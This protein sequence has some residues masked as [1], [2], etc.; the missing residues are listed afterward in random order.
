[1]VSRKSKKSK[2][3][4]NLNHNTICLRFFATC[5]FHF[6]ISKYNSMFAVCLF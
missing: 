2:I 4:E 1:M 3:R 5:L 6:E